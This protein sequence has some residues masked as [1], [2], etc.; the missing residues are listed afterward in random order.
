V[1]DGGAFEI[2][3]LLSVSGVGALA[4]SLV[5]ASLPNRRRSWLMLASSLVLGVS[6]LGFAA[7][8]V[9]WLSALLFVAVGFGQTARWS[10]ASVLIHAYTTDEFRGRV[11]S[12]YNLSWGV[13]SFS[14]FF[15]GLLADRM[16]PQLAIGGTAALLIAIVVLLF[17]SP[18]VR[19]ID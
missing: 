15:V 4:G 14:A 2:G 9:Y 19:D 12:V 11:S 8:T 13:T 6:L 3:T 5:I 17:A 7:S 10:L 1:L 18:S 16:G